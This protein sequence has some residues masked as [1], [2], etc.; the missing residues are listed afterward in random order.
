M[1]A[2]YALRAMCELARVDG[3]RLSA[4]T[5]AERSHVPGKFLETI[6]VELRQAEFIDSR[7]GQQG[8]HALARP[9]GQIAIGDVIRAIDGPLAP[10]RCASVTAYQRC[11]DCPNPDDCNLRALMREARDAL[12][13][14]LDQRSLRDFANSA[15]PSPVP[16]GETP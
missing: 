5:L 16:H 13:Q 11:T 4:R 7:R 9:A 3:Q 14:V 6:L 15:T 8:G 1:K 2:K 10:V 12:S